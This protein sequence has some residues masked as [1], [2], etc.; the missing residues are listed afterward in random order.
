MWAIVCKDMVWLGY[1]CFEGVK[2]VEGVEGEFRF[3]FLC[4]SIDLMWCREI[5]MANST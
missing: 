5:N 4:L 1:A 3:G 2:G